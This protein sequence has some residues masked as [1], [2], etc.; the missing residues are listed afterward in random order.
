VQRYLKHVDYPAT[1]EALIHT[2]ED[3]GADD[4]VLN[5]LGDLPDEEFESPKTV[6]QAIGH[7]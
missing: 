4:A 2:A 7:R 1:K 6:V 3:E 5:T